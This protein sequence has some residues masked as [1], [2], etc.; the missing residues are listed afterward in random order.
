VPSAIIDGVQMEQEIGVEAG[1]AKLAVGHTVEAQFFL[2]G[3][4]LA[5][6]R[7]LSGAQRG[8]VGDIA[9]QGGFAGRRMPSDQIDAAMD[10]ASARL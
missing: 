2:H 3:D 9:S 10:N 8:A 4:D 6:R 7:V 5:D 1:A